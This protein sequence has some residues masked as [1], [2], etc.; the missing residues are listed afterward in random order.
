MSRERLAGWFAKAA[1][2][3]LLV[4]A[5]MGVWLRWQNWGT[6]PASFNFRFLTHA[7]SHLMFL[8]W[9]YNAL[10]ALLILVFLPERPG[11]IYS[12]LFFG[13][14]AGLAGMAVAF[15]LQ[16]Y[17]AVSIAFSTLH[18]VLA[19]WLGLR[20]WLDT[21][22]Q[23]PA[24]AA[25]RWAIVFLIVSS[26]GPF[27]LGYVMAKGGQESI[28]YNLAI[29]FYLHFQYNGWMFFALLAVLL[30]RLPADRHRTERAV[31][32]LAGGCAAAYAVSTLW[33]EPPA[34]VYLLAG[35]GVLLQVWGA[36]LLVRTW[37]AVSWPGIW[38]QSWA[39]RFAALAFYS[40]L[41]KLAVQLLAL[42]PVMGRQ[43]FLNRNWLIAYFHLVFI[44]VISAAVI[45]MFIEKN[46]LPAGRR[47]APGWW[48]LIGGYAVTEMMLAVPASAPGV[49][50]LA[51]AA[52]LMG[53]FWVI[54]AMAFV[55][56]ER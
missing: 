31:H 25:L 16:G 35:A 54:G 34:I 44:G 52:M 17:A 12:W 32:L 37:R 53:L 22:R 36:L 39:R 29:Y 49:L 8:G 24:F 15:P 5:L 28:W 43:V 51:S 20:L 18:M 45:A 1:L 41:L 38:L 47:L 14:Q 4:A 40:F 6:P 46:W 19:G 2:L 9:V 10:A 30:Q 11:R 42:L 21:G 56:R 23:T 48:L 26:A 7:H 50:L 33:T 27:A 13:L 55:A 3:W